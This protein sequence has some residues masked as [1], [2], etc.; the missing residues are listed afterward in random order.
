MKSTHQDERVKT[1]STN[2]CLN[3]GRRVAVQQ[4]D[5]HFYPAPLAGDVQR[6]Y[7]VLHTQAYGVMTA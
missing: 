5:N 2:P 1:A 6:C 7:T 3:V 4:Q